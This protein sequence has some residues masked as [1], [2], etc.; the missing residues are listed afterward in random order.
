MNGLI[1]RM[2]ILKQTKNGFSADGNPVSGVARVER[3]GKLTT[4]QLSLVNFAPL[5][6]GKYLC[7]LCDK[8]GE[9]IVFSPTGAQGEHRADN[10]PFNLEKGFCVL[11]AFVRDGVDCI[12]YGQYGAGSYNIRL[13][14]D[15]VITPEK[16]KRESETAMDESVTFLPAPSRREVEIVRLQT[17]NEPPMPETTGEYTPP[18]PEV[19]YDDEAVSESDYYAGGEGYE[20]GD[21]MSVDANENACFAGESQAVDGADAS[22]NDTAEKLFRPFKVNDGQTYFN[23]VKD[24]IETLF[25]NGERTDDLSRAFPQSEWVKIADADGCLVGIIYEDFAPKYIAYA[26]PSRGERIPPK[27]LT[28][29]CFVPCEPYFIGGQNEAGEKNGKNEGYFVLFQDV[30]TGE[31]VTVKQG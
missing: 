9:R 6:G 3:Y 19:G 7:I 27:E 28:G 31:C 2:C 21:C 25:E 4:V 11:V 30:S 22:K 18:T 14:L 23:A 1:K 10:I 13:L 24:E 20:S 15:G 12:A 16:S 29:A 17:V 5:S 8:A 26:L